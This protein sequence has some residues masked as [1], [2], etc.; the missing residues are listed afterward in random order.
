MQG[1]W[2]LD[3]GSGFHSYTFLSKTIIM[4]DQEQEDPSEPRSF[5]LAFSRLTTST[6]NHV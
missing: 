4:Y 1:T 2:N 3:L 6:R 5:C